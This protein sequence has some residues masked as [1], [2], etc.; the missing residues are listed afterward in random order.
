MILLVSGG[1]ILRAV[2]VAGYD[3]SSHLINDLLSFWWYDITRGLCC[4]V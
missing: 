4:R 3:N 2:C 1:T